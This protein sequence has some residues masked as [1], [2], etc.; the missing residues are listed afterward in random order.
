MRL[1]GAQKTIAPHARYSCVTDLQSSVTRYTKDVLTD[2]GKIDT[3]FVQG[4]S[5]QLQPSWLG[6]E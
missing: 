1:V 2:I 3:Q 5:K 6:T 4:T